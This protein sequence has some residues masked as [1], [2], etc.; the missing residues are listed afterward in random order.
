MAAGI[1]LNLLNK[2]FTRLTVIAKAD[3]IK[4]RTASLCKC[5]CG[6]EKVVKTENL[7]LHQTKS[8]GCLNK[9]KRK[10]NYKKAIKKITKY[11]SLNE[12]YAAAV[13][14]KGYNDGNISLKQFIALSQKNCHYC[15][16][17]PNNNKNNVFYYNG[18]DRIDNSKNHTID[19]VVPCCKHCNYAKNNQTYDDYLLWI[20]Q[21]YNNLTVKD[22]T[23]LIKLG[24]IEK[25]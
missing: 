19:N 23:I 1:K 13:W 24:F 21:V 17:I 14:K 2:T 16:S 22:K 8:C 6:A 9:E 11:K 20:K 12:S 18:L 25:I 7:T 4:G 5:I 10:E 15:G 3:N